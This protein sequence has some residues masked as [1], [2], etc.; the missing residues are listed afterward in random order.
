MKNLTKW[1]AIATMAG[2]LA[3]ASAA[4]AADTVDWVDWTSRT[5]ATTILGTIT[6]G[7]TSVGVQYDGDLLFAQIVPAAPIDYWVDLG[8]TQG[9]V[10][11]PTGNDIIALDAAGLKTITFSQAVVD[12]YLAFTSWNG[13]TVGFSAPFSVVSQGAGYWGTGTFAPNL[14]SD[15][16]F[17]NGEVHGVLK[18]S[19]TFTSLSFTDSG[20]NWHG[21][22]VGIGS[23]PEP[24]TWALM[25]MGFGSVG[26][27]IRRRRPALA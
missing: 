27:V 12:P 5:T 25:I 2:S 7:A 21:F 18:F 9:L 23:V 1:L 20:E 16:F 3:T 22:T 13:N 19:G 14:A 6:S 26:A 11:R 4:A 8:Y 15:G 24:A 10:N 17:G